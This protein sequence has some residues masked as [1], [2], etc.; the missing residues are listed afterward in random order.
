MQ[1]F[2]QIRH[3]YAFFLYF[4]SVFS[5]LSWHLPIGQQAPCHAIIATDLKNAACKYTAFFTNETQTIVK[6]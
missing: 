3:K 6:C 5:P 1:E 4:V 2:T